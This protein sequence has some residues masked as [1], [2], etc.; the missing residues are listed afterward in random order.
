MT[1]PVGV[2]LP[3]SDA[4]FGMMQAIITNRSKTKPK[5]QAG[6]RAVEFREGKEASSKASLA[7]LIGEIYAVWQ[8]N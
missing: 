1:V 6:S 7:S 4:A 3:R 5:R 2:F 8:R